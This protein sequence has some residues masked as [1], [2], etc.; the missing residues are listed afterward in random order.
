[1][2]ETAL[3]TGAEHPDLWWVVVPSFL[4]FLAGL[5][6]GSRADSID[7]WSERRNGTDDTR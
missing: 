2:L 1:M 4:A 5:V 7:A 3:H 6:L